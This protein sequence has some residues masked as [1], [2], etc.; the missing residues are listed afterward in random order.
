MLKART[1]MH[2]GSRYIEVDEPILYF[3]NINISLLSERNT[4]IM[5]RGGWAN[6]PQ[7]VWEDR[8]EVTFSLSEG[9]LSS[10]GM[11][12][13]LSAD[14]LEKK[15]QDELLVRRREGPMQLDQDHCMIL[16]NWPV[17]TIKKKAFIY[18]YSRDTI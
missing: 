10:V 2:F 1:P 13:L 16:K 12:I 15:G 14:V 18:K 9:V 7:V 5:A 4:P 3:E 11:G 6:L 17:D 8:S